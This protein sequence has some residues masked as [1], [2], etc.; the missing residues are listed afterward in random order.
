MSNLQVLFVLFLFKQ[1]VKVP[2]PP[3]TLVAYLDHKTRC[4]LCV[5]ITKMYYLVENQ[6]LDAENESICCFIIFG[7]IIHSCYHWVDISFTALTSQ[8]KWD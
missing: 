6:E 1:T 3:F 7:Q 2:G 5:R 8:P 4:R